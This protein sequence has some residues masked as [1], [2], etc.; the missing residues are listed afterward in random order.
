M[1]PDFLIQKPKG[2]NLKLKYFPTLLM[3]QAVSVGRKMHC[4][5]DALG[6][7]HKCPSLGPAYH[8]LEAQ[9]E[10]GHKGRNRE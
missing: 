4:A 9:L 1:N 7:S 2:W 5:W 8:A 3:V 10:D 6:Q